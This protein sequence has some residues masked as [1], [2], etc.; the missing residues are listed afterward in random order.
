MTQVSFPGPKV[1]AL[2]HISLD[3][4]DTWQVRPLDHLLFAVIEPREEGDYSPNIVVSTER[5]LENTPLASL[6]DEVNQY[7]ASLADHKVIGQTSGKNAKGQEMVAAQYTYTHAV[8]QLAGFLAVFVVR[9]DGVADVFNLTAT[10]S[11]VHAVED[12]ATI[13]RIVASVTFEA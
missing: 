8:G 11:G 5:R 7:V 1:P 9:H 12:I 4:P 10:A 13:Q 3:V 6:T 2:P